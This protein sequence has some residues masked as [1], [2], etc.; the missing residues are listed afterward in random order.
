MTTSQTKTR[1][2]RERRGILRSKWPYIYKDD[3]PYRFVVRTIGDFVRMWPRA[4][5]YGLQYYFDADLR[6]RVRNRHGNQKSKAKYGSGFL[7]KRPLI[8]ERLKVRD[9][10]A[11]SN[12]PNETMLSIDHIVPVSQG[13]TNHLYNLQLLCIPCHDIKTAYDEE[14]SAKT[15]DTVATTKVVQASFEKSLEAKKAWQSYQK[16]TNPQ[17]VTQ[18]VQ[19]FSDI[20]LAVRR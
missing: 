13:G 17:L 8:R 15:K 12:C 10:A 3:T 9:G 14:N 4:M 7:S 19:H 5:E 1:K 20:P 18:R 11:C 6:R 16:E 2:Y